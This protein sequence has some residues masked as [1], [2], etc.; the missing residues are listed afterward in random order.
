[1]SHGSSLGPC[2]TCWRVRLIFLCDVYWSFHALIVVVI[3]IWLTMDCT[4]LWC[5][6]CLHP[7]WCYSFLPHPWRLLHHLSC[8]FV[9]L[10]FFCKCF[11]TFSISSRDISPSDSGTFPSKASVIYLAAWKIA[12]VGVTIGF[13][14]CLCLKNTV[15]VFLLLLFL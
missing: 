6:W 13:V 10:C 3:F 14:V 11:S 4:Y 7:W 5:C 8:C 9:A 12:P 2:V 15:L 1:M